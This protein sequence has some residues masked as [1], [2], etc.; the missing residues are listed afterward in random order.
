MRT[1]KKRRW[2]LLFASLVL[3][4]HGALAQVQRYPADIQPIL[5]APYSVYLSD[6]TAEGSNR[7]SA[8][9]VFNDFNEASWTFKLRLSIESMDV[10]LRTKNGFTPA[11]PITVQPGVPYVF[12][13]SDWAEYF[14]FN[15]L[16][17]SGRNTSQ[18]IN[19]GRLPE[20]MYSICLQVLDYNTGELLS[21][22]SCA[23]VWIQLLD[24][25]R[26][27]SPTDNE[28]LD[29]ATTTSFP[30]TWQLF[31][32]ASANNTM[33]TDFQLT[34]WELTEPGAN[35]LSAVQNGQ[36]LQVFQSGLLQ[37]TNYTYGPADPLLEAGK[38]YVYRVQAIDADGKD[39]YKNNGYSEFRLLY[40]GWPTGGKIELTSPPYGHSFRRQIP[41][42]V[43]W[44]ALTSRA[45]EQGVNYEINIKPLSPG[46]SPEDALRENSQWYY[47]LISENRTNYPKSE[48]L[49]Y[50]DIDSGY[51]W[52]VKGYTNGLEVA[53]SDISIF[54][55]PPLVERFYAA[56]HRIEVDNITNKDFASF[57]GTGR[58]RL[59]REEVWTSIA[60]EN[61]QLRQSGYSAYLI[62]GEINIETSP[63]AFE[64]TPGNEAD[65]E[66]TFLA[67]NYKVTKDGLF[68]E[69]SFS[70]DL[71][72]PLLSSGI[73]KVTSE[74]FASD[75]NDFRLS[76]V[77]NLTNGN[78]FELLDPQFFR[79]DLSPTSTVV[80][81]DNQYWFGFDGTL[82]TPS[83]K[84]VTGSSAT[85]AFNQVDNLRLI[86]ISDSTNTVPLRVV[87]GTG[88]EL[89]PR[90]SVIDLDDASSPG[91]FAG[92][93]YWKGVYIEQSTLKIAEAMDGAGQFALSSE[94]ESS[95]DLN[96][97]PNS[98]VGVTGE[99]FTLKHDLHFNVTGE[100]NTFPAN[101]TRLTLDI[102]NQQANEA[103]RLEG[104]FLVPFIDTTTPF[105]FHSQ[106]YDRGFRPGTLANLNNKT[107]RFNPEGGE[108]AVDLTIRK[109]EMA[110]NDHLRLTMDVTWP[111]VGVTLSGVNNFN[112]WGD[113]RVGFY[114]P[115]GVL[116]LTNQ[117]NAIFRGYPVTIDALSAGRT[118]N[119]YGF[120]ISGK[121]VMGEDV[122][123]DDGAP[124]FNLYSMVEN[125]VLDKSYM[126]APT[127][128]AF[129]LASAQNGLDQLEEGLAAME[130]D[131][132]Q[133]VE[134]QTEGLKS[135]TVDLIASASG[136]LGGQAHDVASLVSTPEEPAEIDY[137]AIADRKE[138]LLAY[139]ELFRELA[140]DPTVV[141]GLI[142]QVQNS[143]EDFDNISDVVAELKRFA[144]N[145]AIDK[146]ASLGDGFLMKVD[147]ATRNINGVIIGKA[148]QL[149]SSVQQ[150]LDQA[151]TAIITTVSSDVVASI[152]QDA[153]DAALVVEQ[154]ANSTREAIV[155]E[156]TLALNASVNQ[157]IVSPVT[158]F[159]SSNL[160]ERAR[161]LV[162]QTAENVV[163]GALNQDQNPSEIMEGVL[164]G[165]DDELKGLGDELGAQV[166]MDKMLEAIKSVGEDLIANI[167]ADRIVNQIKKGALEAISG[168]VAKKASIAANEMVNNLLGEEVGISIPV[169]FAAVGGKLLSGANPKDLLF[170]PIPIS[171]RS[172]ALD[173]NG[174]IHFTKGHAQYGDSWSGDVDAF[175]KV[176]KPFQIQLAYLSGRKDNVSFWMAEVGSG[177]SPPT[178]GEPADADKIGQPMQPSTIKEVTDEI[179]LGVVKIVALQGRV[180]R[181]MAS[182]GLEG[183]VPDGNNNYGAYLHMVAFGPQNGK[184]LRLEID[185]KMDVAATGDFTV[186][187]L[188]NGQMLSSVPQVA[189]IDQT[190]VIKGTIAL[191]YNS[192]E[193]HFFGHLA[194]SFEKPGVLCAQ[195]S[196]LVDVKPGAWRVALG[197]QQERLK[198]ILNC[199]G[200]GPTGWLDLN[201]NTANLGL[202]LEF[203]FKPNPIHVNIAIVEFDLVI[204]AGAAAGVQVIAQYNPSFQLQEAGLW[205]ELWAQIYAQYKKKVSGNTGTITLVDIYLAANANMRFNP[206]PS[207]L[208]GKVNGHLQILVFSF[209][210][211][212]DFQMNL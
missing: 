89:L 26:L 56:S 207:I 71:P 199:A 1:T 180:Y 49:P 17:V 94:L 57:S 113:Y 7:L 157:N 176:P 104:N 118:Q 117:V 133:K 154:V 158:S 47:K 28:F 159:V 112:V 170:D 52:Q 190:A 29:P 98:L 208:Y 34:M 204:E 59:S 4:V 126:P 72:F 185:A 186:D 131:L 182:N 156:L 85:W 67:T 69:G 168:A 153:P 184:M 114:V 124:A 194:A 11:S 161:R 212:K 75:F 87:A 31:N 125:P 149:T 146:V 192:A 195:G 151:V 105:E 191:K 42:V 188:G 70:W 61:L 203:M 43:K 45:P 60:F 8:N 93:P 132:T 160:N 181:H 202:G 38:A 129:N 41:A 102:N 19:S 27:I 106:L 30:I 36:A 103:S 6:Y 189:T 91:K 127:Q 50:P 33:G 53:K 187:F 64:L 13:G 66:A 196:L 97:L 10:R 55:G 37:N 90:K 35:P 44:N 32:T 130:E 119:Y 21:Q 107:F 51:V 148:N 5:P 101:F 142:E 99:G 177:G 134:Q 169:D 25:P 121:V 116:A 46:E 136:G 211:N 155:N 145:F 115:E 122:S 9:I 174:I 210:I 167:S 20:G 84:S 178:P 16:N 120:A 88:M 62:G 22:E 166:D 171:V 206:A 193:Q 100:F 81:F 76:G 63:I 78:S 95:I 92:E 138:R 179:E 200:F 172:P 2:L 14:N 141:D 58:V 74:K 144:T 77:A 205:L 165:F 40:Y 147:L 110:S 82:T 109:G 128:G 23:N 201:Q 79:L 183:I 18:I 209:G 152:S 123:G 3:V 12:S 83:A 150:E 162:R 173:L 48:L 96:T 143:E 139:L 164:N 140:S 80:I 24:P 65:G 197:S 111:S 135:T 163:L 137:E 39:R 198:F 108:L 73:G 15:N 54:Y 175:V 86:E 68:V